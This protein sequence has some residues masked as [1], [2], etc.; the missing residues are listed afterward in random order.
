MN[1]GNEE[2]Q[3]LLS[4]ECESKA[5]L[6]RGGHKKVAA[7]LAESGARMEFSMVLRLP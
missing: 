1:S 3:G 5:M 4:L 2:G 6:E 7:A